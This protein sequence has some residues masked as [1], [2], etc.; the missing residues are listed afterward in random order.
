MKKINEIFE[1]FCNRYRVKISPKDQYK[2]KI[3]TPFGGLDSDPIVFN[4]KL[5]NENTLIL[6]DALATYMFYDKNFYDPSSNAQDIMMTI[7]KTYGLI[8]D[9][10]MK[11]FEVNKNKFNE[12]ADWFNDNPLI[13]NE[14]NYFSRLKY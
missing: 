11:W 9:E 10:F 7:L 8:E 12:F 5:E 14:K 6:D 13:V 4:A 1:E 2:A 3:T